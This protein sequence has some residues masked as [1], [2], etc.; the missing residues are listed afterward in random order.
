MDE[1]RFECGKHPKDALH[2]K[3]A[4]NGDHLITPFQCHY[5][6]FWMLTGWIPDPS[7]FLDSQLICCLIRANLDAFWGQEPNTVSANCRNLELLIETWCKVGIGLTALPALG[8]YPREEIF[9]VSIAVGMLLKSLQPGHLTYTHFE[10][11]ASYGP[12]FPIC[13]MLQC[14]VPMAP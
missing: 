6:L 3:V 8:P 11:I 12:P 10:T 9:G 13:I 5:C 7:N 2:Y 4:R 1:T 14:K